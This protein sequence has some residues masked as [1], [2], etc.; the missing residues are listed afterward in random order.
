MTI[1]SLGY[2]FEA[3]D[4]QGYTDTADIRECEIVSLLSLGVSKQ[5]LGV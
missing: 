1:A 2:I 5:R 3:I 4:V